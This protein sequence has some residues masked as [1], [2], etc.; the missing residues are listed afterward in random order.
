[1]TDN[2]LKRRNQQHYSLIRSMQ[3]LIVVRISIGELIR[4]ATRDRVTVPDAIDIRQPW[5][6]YR[7][8]QSPH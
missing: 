3:E 6:R 4:P 5:T 7:A 2:G 8:T 1:M